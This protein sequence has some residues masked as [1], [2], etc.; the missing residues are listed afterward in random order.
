MSRRD[1]NFFCLWIAGF[2]VFIVNLKRENYKYQI[3]FF[4]I[5]HITIIT[6]NYQIM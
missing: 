6:I 4:A 1:F 5:T 3:D 2:V